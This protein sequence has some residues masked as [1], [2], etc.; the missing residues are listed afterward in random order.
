MALISD[1]S[2]RW[3]WIHGE[4]FATFVSSYL[5]E[6]LHP[7]AP[8]AEDFPLS[9]NF[10]MNLLRDLVHNRLEYVLSLDG[11]T[12]EFNG[13]TPGSI[14]YL[15]IYKEFGMEKAIEVFSAMINC[16][17]GSRIP[18]VNNILGANIQNTFP[19]WYDNNIHRIPGYW[20]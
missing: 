4:G 13:R 3:S 8:T 6:Y 7:N 12:A 2:I 16:P 19:V 20:G 15:Y 18:I 9:V 1:W 5:F 17:S 14:F 11:G 10:N